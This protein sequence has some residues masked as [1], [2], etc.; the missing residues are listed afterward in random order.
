MA[1][2]GKVPEW[3][4]LQ[5]KVFTR[6]INQKFQ[7]ANR[8]E[9]I[10]NVLTDFGDGIIF[11]AFLEALSEAKCDAKWNKNKLRVSHVDNINMALEFAKKLGVAV[12]NFPQATDF[13]DGQ[14]RPVLG[15]VWACILKFLKFGDD[16]DDSL[17][18]KDAL[19]LWVKNKTAGYKGVEIEKFPNSF[20]DGLALCALIHSNRPSLVAY[21][22]LE[23]GD[24]AI[25]AAF[26]GAEKYFE[27]EKFVTVD[28]FK[29]S[30]RSAWW[31]TSR[32]TTMA[33]RVRGR[34]TELPGALRR[35]RSSPRTWTR[36]RPTSAW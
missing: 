21:D 3:V 20:R 11:G 9:R 10:N 1:A 33:W 16:A 29:R 32:T 18:A 7:S 34:R 8:P 23:G 17:N 31:C 12:K 30:T 26:D 36:E 2:L 19:L 25:E 15:F 27:M 28:E 24:A 22:S 14:E 5:T 4:A 35:W 6:W 13:I